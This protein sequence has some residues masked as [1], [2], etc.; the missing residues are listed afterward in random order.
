MVGWG[1]MKWIEIVQIRRSR[2][3]FY[4]WFHQICKKICFFKKNVLKQIQRQKFSLKFLTK[5]TENS[6]KR[7]IFLTLIP[8]FNKFLINPTTAPCHDSANLSNLLACYS[9]REK[10]VDFFYGIYGKTFLSK[11]IWVKRNKKDTIF[12]S[13]SIILWSLA[14]LHFSLTGWSIWNK[15]F[16][17]D[18]F[19]CD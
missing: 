17:R 16:F 7:G 13:D 6:L 12:F 19:S 5:I 15:M 2:V 9:L 18:I 11:S 8:I 1:P 4:N 14:H 10:N 3:L